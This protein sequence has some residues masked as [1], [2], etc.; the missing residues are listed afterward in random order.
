MP[1]GAVHILYNAQEG[2]REGRELTICYIG[3]IREGDVFA[4]VIL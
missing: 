3:Y 1:L 2:G 4:N